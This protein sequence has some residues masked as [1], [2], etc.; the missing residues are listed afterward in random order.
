MSRKHFSWLLLVTFLVALVVLMIPGRTAKDSSFE[1]T[2]L[3]PEAASVINEIDWLR[4]TAAGNE[5]VATLKREGSSWVVVEASAY[6]ADWSR[7]KSL[8]SG[9]TQAEIIELKTARPDY[10]SRL[11][12]AD[13]SS[14]EAGGVMVEF[15]AGSSLP[16]VI[17]G[18]SA[19]GREG[20]YV[21]LQ[22]S[23]ESALIDRRLDV[24]AERSAWLEK[25]IVDISDA[26]VVEVRIVHP[27]GES[28]KAVKASADDEN[29][30]LQAIPEGREIKSAWSVNS[31]A[32]LLAALTLEE[33]MPDSGFDWSQ[34]IRFSLLTADGLLLD[35]EL[36]ADEGDDEQRWIR[37]QAGLYTT[38]LESGVESEQ[39]DAGPGARAETINTRVSGWAYRIPVYKYDS[40]NKRMDDLLKPAESP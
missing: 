22:G 2:T 32:G 33:V 15:S 6:P 24:P 1:K 4:L 5:V 37:L 19:Q 30:E 3:I 38:A 12:V 17:I 26:E 9:L 13:V 7:L 10:Y 29:F 39:G 11:G 18:N 36:L 20:Q 8:L 28:I 21:R 23:A 16:A 35:A 34:A 31:L 14:P 40:M 25:D 27:D